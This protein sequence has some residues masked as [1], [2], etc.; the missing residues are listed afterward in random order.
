MNYQEEKQEN[1]YLKPVFSLPFQPPIAQW[2]LWLVEPHKKLEGKVA[3]WCSSHSLHPK[4]EEDLRY[5]WKRSSTSTQVC[6]IMEKLTVNIVT[7]LNKGKALVRRKR[8]NKASI[9]FS[10][11]AP[12]NITIRSTLH[13]HSFLFCTT[14][15]Q[16]SSKFMTEDGIVICKLIGLVMGTIRLELENETRQ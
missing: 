13:L 9:I 11:V 1:N 6:I 15:I 10:Y 14:S 3:H 12:M 7:T 2:F 8:G 16:Y 4:G 5:K